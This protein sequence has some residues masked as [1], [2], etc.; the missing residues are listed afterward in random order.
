MRKLIA[1]DKS[2]KVEE[3]N[4]LRKETKKIENG[5]EKRKY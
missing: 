4:K 5:K 3:G 1:V 2:R